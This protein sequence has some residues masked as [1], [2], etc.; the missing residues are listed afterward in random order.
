LETTTADIVCAKRSHS[1]GGAV[2]SEAWKLFLKKEKNEAA[3]LKG[4]SLL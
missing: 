3:D 4:S 1:F 2:A